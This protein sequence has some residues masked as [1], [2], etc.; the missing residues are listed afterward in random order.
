M[1]VSSSGFYQMI[2][3]NT[4]DLFN[5]NNQ[6]WANDKPPTYS[7]IVS[8]IGGNV[9]A[10]MCSGI[11]LFLYVIGAMGLLFWE[12]WTRTNNKHHEQL[13]MIGAVLFFTSVLGV[14]VLFNFAYS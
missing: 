6:T 7:E 14:Q 9:K 4:S 1:G 2:G 12:L 3:L 10:V 5:I 13:W 8:M 11:A